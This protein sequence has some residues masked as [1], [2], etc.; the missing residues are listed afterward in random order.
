[1]LQGYQ[2]SLVHQILF[3]VNQQAGDNSADCKAA[4]IALQLCIF[5]TIKMI[6]DKNLF[7]QLRI[8]P[9][10]QPICFTQHL[11]W[12]VPFSLSLSW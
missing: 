7:H 12:F 9:V 5:Q 3:I 8:V 1:M 11:S 10:N 6:V 4:E 2:T